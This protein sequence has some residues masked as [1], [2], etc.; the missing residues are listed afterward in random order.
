[1]TKSFVT[2]FEKAALYGTAP[3]DWPT[4]GLTATAQADA[5][6]NADPLK[7]LD[8]AMSKLEGNGIA[9]GGILGGAALRAALRAQ[10]VVTL[11]AKRSHHGSAPAE[12]DLVG[13]DG[14]CRARTSDLLGVNQ[15]LSQLS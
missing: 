14:R 2:V 8:A 15:A 11:K 6:T 4:G 12:P 7:A 5:V 3:N 9:P 13:R 10:T 1:M